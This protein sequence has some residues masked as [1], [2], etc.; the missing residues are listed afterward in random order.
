[1]KPRYSENPVPAKTQT[2][3]A[4]QSN[5]QTNNPRIVA[6]AAQESAICVDFE[7]YP[8]HPRFKTPNENAAQPLP[9][10]SIFTFLPSQ[11]R[12]L[13]ILP[14]LLLLLHRVLQLK[15]SILSS[16]FPRDAIQTDVRLL[17]TFDLEESELTFVLLDSQ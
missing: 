6:N 17:T 2:H 1:M 8:H 7:N 14:S 11:H 13:N 9:R 10:H 5:N 16:A 15:P 12:P 4:N 3:S